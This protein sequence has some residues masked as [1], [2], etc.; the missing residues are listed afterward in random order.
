M[1][2]KIKISLWIL[3][4]IIILAV[5]GM[6]GYYGY[7]KWRVYNYK[8]TVKEP[9]LKDA[10]SSQGGETPLEAYKEFRQALKKGDKEQ[11]LQY[12]FVEEREEYRKDLEKE[13]RVE[14]YLDM[15]G[16]EELEKDS[17]SDCGEEA[18]ACRE[19]AEFYYEYEVEETKKV[20]VWGEESTVEPGTYKDSIT[21]IKNLAGKWQINSL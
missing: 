15:P 10:N 9:Y 12:V 17:R 3:L 4:G 16:A 14:K 5:L 13:E 7:G 19:K 20:E 21:F 1:N 11:A 8:Q 2:K 18:L 6:A